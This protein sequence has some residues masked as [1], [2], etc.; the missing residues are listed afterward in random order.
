MVIQSSERATYDG[1]PGRMYYVSIKLKQPFEVG[2]LDDE[3]VVSR[4][5]QY[6][7]V[8]YNRDLEPMDLEVAEIKMTQSGRFDIM[9]E[10]EVEVFRPDD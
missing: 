6:Q 1:K 9:R 4:R 5:A 8:L 10:Y 2:P 7:V 3:K